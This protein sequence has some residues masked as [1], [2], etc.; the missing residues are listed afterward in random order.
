MCPSRHGQVISSFAPDLSSCIELKAIQ[1]D[2]RLLLYGILTI[3]Y[4]FDLHLFDSQEVLRASTDD[5]LSIAAWCAT[6]FCF[7]K[8]VVIDALAV[9]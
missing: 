3:T 8:N 2:S 9:D 7:F 4:L 6:L 1:W 5:G